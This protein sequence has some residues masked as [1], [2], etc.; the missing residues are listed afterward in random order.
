MLIG[1]N[2]LL[3]TFLMPVFLIFGA[4]L[5]FSIPNGE[6]RAES[7]IE[8]I[9]SNGVSYLTSGLKSENYLLTQNG[10]EKTPKKNGASGDTEDSVT[11]EE[12]QSDSKKVIGAVQFCQGKFK[13]L[14][15]AGVE[16]ITLECPS[17][18]DNCS[19]EIDNKSFSKWIECGGL[20]KDSSKGSD[21]L[22]CE[23]VIVGSGASNLIE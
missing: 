11:T 6:I 12:K 22:S 18:D 10:K 9:N 17:A 19:C 16:I 3:E 14:G 23:S 21:L 5:I 2:K 8:G 13:K 15:G 20:R 7:G 1:L 4:L